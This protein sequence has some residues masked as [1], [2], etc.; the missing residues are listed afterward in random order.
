MEAGGNVDLHKRVSQYPIVPF[1]VFSAS[2]LICVVSAA[3]PLQYSGLTLYFYSCCT[4]T[5]QVQILSK[6]EPE[7]IMITVEQI[8]AAQKANLDVLFGLTEK[9]FEGVEKLVQL[10]VAASKAAF[11]ESAAHAQAMLSVKDVQEL[12]TLQTEVVQPLGDKV[13]SY[14]RHV[15]EIA[16]ST[17]TEFTNA[18]EAQFADAQ[19]SV[20]NYIET[21]SKNAPA[22]T[23][24]A[25]A[26]LKNAVAAS[27]SAI[28][29]VQK[30]VKQASQAAEANLQA[31]TQSAVSA[32][33]TAARSKR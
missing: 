30:V 24:P 7:P 31:V 26:V 16:S 20:L 21:V 5:K 2:T 8:S 22:G 28:E 9:T 15:Y 6:P 18:I 14:G 32:V 12:V 23:E 4:A 17:T 11:N 25:V 1:S 33:K 13:N 3:K 10:N 29:S 27:N 19:K